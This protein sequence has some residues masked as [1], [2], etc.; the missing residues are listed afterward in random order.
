MT[1]VSGAV[2]IFITGVCS[3]VYL[4]DE[5]YHYRS[6][7]Q[8]Y[9]TKSRPLV[10]TLVNSSR[11][12]QRKIMVSQLWHTLLAVTWMLT[13]GVSQPA[14]QAYQATGY[15]LL[16]VLTYIL[17]DKYFNKDI[18]LLSAF[19]VATIPLF[20]A[21][22][23][24][25]YLDVLIAALTVLAFLCLFKKRYFWLGVVVAL[26]FLEKR[27]SYLLFPFFFIYVLVFS[28]G[29]FKNRLKNTVFFLVPL[30]VLTLPDFQFRYTKIGSLT[31]HPAVIK[32]PLYTAPDLK[33]VFIHPESWRYEPSN[34]IKFLGIPFLAGF[35]IYIIRFRGF[36][37]SREEKILLAAIVSY[38]IFYLYL[39]RDNL[40]V[41]YMSP[42][43]PITCILCAKAFCLY[44]GK[45]K[46][47]VWSFIVLVGCM[48]FLAALYYVYG[49]RKI[50]ESVWA[51][52]SY[53]EE[54]TRPD[55]RFLTI[56]PA[57]S[58]YTGRKSIWHSD[59]SLPEIGYLFWK[60]DE[61][62]AKA[63][64]DCYEIDY[65]FVDN[66]RIYDDPELYDVKNY[67]LSF[68]QKLPEFSFCTSVFR[69]DSVNIWEIHH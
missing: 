40:A 29:T 2:F 23:V 42:I 67:P 15:V 4:G 20:G 48:Q 56:R 39:F 36:E 13:G 22:S 49:R 14:A 46:V 41:R 26:M 10:D 12:A 5:V 52:Y 64:F 54:H 34:I 21:Y 57:L 58:L 65:I 38:F 25:L 45:R 53:I 69:N 16:V 63:I 37:K 60:A 8:I 32:H 55:S 66:D 68:V 44:S 33:Y 47:L 30:I 31:H 18:G 24:M 9:E 43:I 62:E 28:E 27:N 61:A 1:A 7:Q 6:A 3:D 35:I 19:I 11:V 17:G 51:A 59:A 50:P